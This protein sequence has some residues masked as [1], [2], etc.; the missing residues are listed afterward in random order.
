M[1]GIY[2][3]SY[4]TIMFDLLRLTVLR[5][6]EFLKIKWDTKEFED[7]GQPSF[8]PKLDLGVTWYH[9]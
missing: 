1:S 7:L 3:E 5:I 4:Y 9:V 6:H 8:L 2:L